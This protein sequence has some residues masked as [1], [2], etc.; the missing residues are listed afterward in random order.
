[1][2]LLSQR[3]EAYFHGFLGIAVIGPKETEGEFTYCTEPCDSPG[4]AACS[5]QGEKRSII[6]Q[7]NT[8]QIQVKVIPQQ[9]PPHI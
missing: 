3:M 4:A 5:S 8:N 9:Q 7:R 2:L 6:Q 1:M